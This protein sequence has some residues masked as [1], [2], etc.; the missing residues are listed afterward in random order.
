MRET[1]VALDEVVDGVRE[2]VEHLGLE[3]AAEPLT[4]LVGPWDP[5]GLEQKPGQGQGQGQEPDYLVW[6]ISF[7]VKLPV[8]KK[9]E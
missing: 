7:P 5:Y 6:S 4:E 3:F 1:V 2:A 8:K 9:P